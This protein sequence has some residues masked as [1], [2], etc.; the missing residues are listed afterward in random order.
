MKVNM[1]LATYCLAVTAA[2]CY[3]AASDKDAAEGRRLAEAR[4]LRAEV[5][6]AADESAEA[7]RAADTL[8]VEMDE[9][10]KKVSLARLTEPQSPEPDDSGLPEVEGTQPCLAADA[11]LNCAGQQPEPEAE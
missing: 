4:A 6:R 10:V 2:L 8:L 5:K 3:E 7:K 1:F 9:L 11:G